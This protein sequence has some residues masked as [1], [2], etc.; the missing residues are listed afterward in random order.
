M[1]SFVT[2]EESLIV[3]KSVNYWGSTHYSSSKLTY[4]L[5][6]ATFPDYEWSKYYWN[7]NYLYT[8]Q[9]ILSNFYS[10]VAVLFPSRSAIKTVQPRMHL[11]QDISEHLR[12]QCTINQINQQTEW[13]VPFWHRSTTKLSSS[14]PLFWLTFTLIGG[15][16][17]ITMVKL[18]LHL[19][20]VSKQI[21]D[22]MS[23]RIR[24]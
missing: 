22:I 16:I 13:T 2:V 15:T 8:K 1:V 7:L 19:S 14:P 18:T 20:I 10:F 24:G 4:R 3:K 21:R 9:Y 6:N 12:S 11:V 5:A 17:I 23:W